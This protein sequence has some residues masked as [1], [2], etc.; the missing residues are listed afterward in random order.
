MSES[1]L[2]Q[3]LRVG[4]LLPSSNTVL[5]PALGRRLPPGASLH[6]ARLLVTESS[7]AAVRGIHDALPEAARVIATVRPHVIVVGCTR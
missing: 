1:D 6:T 2:D 4:L 7:A 5:E 3:E